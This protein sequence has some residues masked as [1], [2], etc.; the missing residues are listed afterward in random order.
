MKVMPLSP[1]SSCSLSSVNAIRALDHLQGQQFLM[2]MPAWVP[3]THCPLPKCRYFIYGASTY[4]SRKCS[5][6]PLV[7][8]L[9]KKCERDSKGYNT[10]YHIKSLKICTNISTYG[11]LV[12][13][14]IQTYTMMLNDAKRIETTLDIL[15]LVD[16]YPLKKIIKPLL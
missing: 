13:H 2:V 15:T 14:L 1:S 9:F 3:S 11:S 16:C 10:K 5:L 7:M 8:Y 12:L 6:K 4:L